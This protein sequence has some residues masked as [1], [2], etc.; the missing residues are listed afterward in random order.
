MHKAI[1][2]IRE[3]NLL[4][5]ADHVLVAISGGRDSVALAHFLKNQ[6]FQIALAHINYSLRAK[7]SDDDEAFVRS[8]ALTWDVPLHILNATADMQTNANIQERARELR[9]AYFQ[10]LCDEHGY[11]KVAVGHH[12][13]DSLETVLLNFTRGTGILGM[14]GISAMRNSI[15]RPL[16]TT[17]R[18][19]IE[20]YIRENHLTYRDDSS[21]DSDK[22]SRNRIRHH[23]LPELKTQTENSLSRITKSL[24]LIQEDSEALSS[25]ARLILENTPDG[26]CVSLDRIPRSCG[27]TWI[28]HCIK[29]FGFN[30]VQCD[31]LFQG[32]PGSIIKSA[33]H[34]ATIQDGELRIAPMSAPPEEL[35]I[36][37]EGTYQM[38]GLNIEVSSNEFQPHL[39]PRSKYD[40]WLRSDHVSFPLT[41][42][43]WRNGDRIQP[44]G[45]QYQVLVSDY[46]KDKH[47]DRLSKANTLVLCSGKGEIAWLI[48]YTISENFKCTNE[49]RM[50][51]SIKIN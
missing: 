33:T 27:A 22:Y 42:R 48:G 10:S 19:E 45:L 40:V 17:P 20:D 31:D 18:S 12:L 7:E 5:M 43:P 39:L 13:E 41:F 47:A 25:M 1:A 8:I 6:G 51:V 3:K 34:R 38:E 50:V 44:L 46:L 36:Q 32:N 30:R 49:T 35:I 29:D 24:E 16:L 9:Y 21:N 14:G 28:Y 2:L 4:T 15:I 37:H 23:V 26:H 11:T